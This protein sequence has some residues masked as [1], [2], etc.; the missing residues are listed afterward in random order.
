H[1]FSGGMRQRVMIAMALACDPRLLIADEPTTALDVTVQAQILDLLRRLQLERRMGMMLVTHDFGVVAEIADRVAVL[2]AGRVVEMARP[3]AILKAAAH[4]YSKALAA[5]VPR[6]DDADQ[7][8]PT[9]AGRPA[10]LVDAPQGCAFAPRC[11]MRRDICLRERPPLREVALGR[12]AAC[13]F[14]E[15]VLADA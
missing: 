3:E 13:H 1:E 12:M 6:M 11:P 9:I 7:Q 15:E 5:C 2:Y 10:S 14:S 8:L 4:P